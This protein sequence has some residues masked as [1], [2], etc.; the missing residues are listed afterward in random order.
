MEYIVL[1]ARCSQQRPQKAT[2]R[3][4]IKTIAKVIT[5]M[6]TNAKTTTTNKDDSGTKP[7]FI[8]LLYINGYDLIRNRRKKTTLTKINDYKLFN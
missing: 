5:E 6:K 4:T 2:T 3:I 8:N 1:A 7:S